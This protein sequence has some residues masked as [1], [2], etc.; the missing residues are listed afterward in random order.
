MKLG[1][2]RSISAEI[3]TASTADIAFLLIV[4]FMVTTV[5]SATKGLDFDLP[6]EEPT[7][8]AVESVEAVYIQID[9]NGSIQV[10]KTPMELSQLLDYLEPKMAPGKG[11]PNK[12]VIIRPSP[13]TPYGALVD[14]YDELRL[15]ERRKGFPIKNI[16]IPTQRET[17]EYI[18]K[19]GINPFDI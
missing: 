15:C 11:N 13:D 8:Q 5:F 7:A 17:E 18:Q 3:P 2:G 9:A 14:V 10:D 6:K 4:F 19:F 16:S 12:P 1:K